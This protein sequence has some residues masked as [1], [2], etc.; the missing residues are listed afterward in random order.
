MVYVS[1]NVRGVGWLCDMVQENFH[2]KMDHLFALTFL[3][4]DEILGIDAWRSQPTYCLVWQWC[5]CPS[6]VMFLLGLWFGCVCILNGFP[7]STT[8]G[9]HCLGDAKKWSRGYSS[10]N[11]VNYR[12][13]RKEQSHTE[14]EW[15]CILWVMPWKRE[16]R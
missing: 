8:A 7:V 11:T 15:E 13:M 1:R 6:L 2:L 5:Y 10:W 16:S 4:D 9:K 12:K 14:E 3:P